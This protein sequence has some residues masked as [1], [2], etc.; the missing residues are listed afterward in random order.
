MRDRF[1]LC[2]SFEKVDEVCFLDLL[3]TRIW[4]AGENS[5]KTVLAVHCSKRSFVGSQFISLNSF[6]PAVCLL[7]YSDSNRI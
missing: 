3:V 4:P 5:L 1:A 2:Y 6:I 7:Y